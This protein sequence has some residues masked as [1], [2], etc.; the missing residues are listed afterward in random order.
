[1][2]KPE[3]SE[4][5]LISCSL[6]MDELNLQ[7]GDVFTDSDAKT[8]LRST[9]NERFSETDLTM[10]LG[11]P[12]RQMVH[13]NVVDSQLSEGETKNH[14]LFIQSKGFKVEVKFPKNWNSERKTPSNSKR[15]DEYQRDFDWLRGELQLGHKGK[16]AFVIG[17]FNYV[18]YFA[19]IMQ[20]GERENGKRTGSNPIA[21]KRRLAYLPFLISEKEPTHTKD[22]VYNYGCAYKELV[23]DQVD[24]GETIMNCIFL[25]S[26]TDVFHFAIYY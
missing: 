1:M 15:W 3:I 19:Q 25:G 12:F 16:C 7:Y 2:K 17:W 5:L 6:V 10:R 18:D 13:Y 24:C 9:V 26:E 4:Y 20:L 21:S 23:L 8:L 11:Y 22:L 14:D